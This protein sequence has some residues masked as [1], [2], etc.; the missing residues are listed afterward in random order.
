MPLEFRPFDEQ[1]VRRLSTEIRV[2]DDPRAVR[3]KPVVAQL[4]RELF[5]YWR[6]R[7]DGKNDEAVRRFNEARDRARQL[8]LNYATADELAAGSLKEIL[9]RV[10]LLLERGDIENEVDVAAI[11]GGEQR[12][13]LRVAGLVAEYESIEGS[14]L[15]KL[16]DTQRRKAH[17]TR[18]RSLTN[19]Q[20][21]IGGDKDLAALDRNDGLKF[22]V[23]L[24]ARVATGAID[25]VT[26]NR[27]MGAVSA[28]LKTV[29]LTHQL[30]LPAIF[31]DL[32]IKGAVVRQRVPFS[33]QWIRTKILA[34]GALDGLNEE[35][36]DI[37]Y[38]MIDH[39]FRPSEISDAL[40][41][42]LEADPPWVWVDPTRKKLKTPE[43]ARDVPLVGRGPEV[44]R[45]RA[46]GFPRYRGKDA[47]SAVANKYFAENG[48]METPE[49]TI[50]GLRHSFEDRLNAVETPEKVVASLMGHKWQRPKYG[51]GPTLEQKRRWLE[52][53][54][55]T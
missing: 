3:A 34:P 46:K 9:A 30:E 15:L 32:R 38:L 20:E 39:G 8:H 16:N 25:I 5:A 13:K 40:T 41:P 17:G 48:L 55:L 44:M 52:K 47:F 24:A 36:R 11:L 14:A 12:P 26:A 54:S 7:R 29:S 18:Q 51:L 22:R 4:D 45:R 27:E 19:F 37:I 31:A 35:A 49:H 33:E 6:G 50:Y 43:S 23:A 1:P 10:N 53:I 42:H 28:M 2:A 21:A